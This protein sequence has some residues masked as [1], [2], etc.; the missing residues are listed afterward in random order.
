MFIS[1]SIFKQNKTQKCQDP[2]STEL[3]TQTTLEAQIKHPTDPTFIQLERGS[4]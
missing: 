1:S 4:I 3:K 2:S